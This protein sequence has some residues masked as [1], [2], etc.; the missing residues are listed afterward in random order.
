[1]M[2][3]TGVTIGVLGGMG[4][5]ASAEFHREL[6]RRTPA[7]TDQE[8]HRIL[9]LDDPHIPDRTA[10]LL[11]SG[12]DPRPALCARVR[13]LEQFGA[14]LIAIPCNT[15]HAFWDE[16]QAA[17]SI[18]VMH[19]VETTVASIPAGTGTVAILATRGT[20]ATGL[21]AAALASAGLGALMP[22]EA[23]QQRVDAVIEG[24]K[25]GRERGR[26]AAELEAVCRIVHRDGAD[27]A[28]LGCTELGMQAADRE[29]HLAL[30]DSVVTLAE[31]TLA[32]AA[33]LEQP[34]AA[35]RS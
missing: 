26:L 17:V 28:I 32:K 11:G 2:K 13:E 30:Y 16:M 20:L 27:A 29:S 1:M 34:L 19:I 7:E 14:D 35:A 22:E 18:P 31:A 23:V 5:E 21:Y 3:R 4:P 33:E 25:R 6:I 12:D 10:F 9:V 24:A 8:H 15:A